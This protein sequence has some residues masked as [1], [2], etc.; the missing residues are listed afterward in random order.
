MRAALR[1][2][3]SGEDRGGNRGRRGTVLQGSATR[4]AGR[5]EP[6][7]VIAGLR[8]RGAPGEAVRGPG[9][10]G[11]VTNDNQMATGA[12][13]AVTGGLVMAFLG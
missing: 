7:A 5:G 10:Q 4:T 3:S 8:D 12:L 11:V 2:C 1:G 13:E 9:T 6:G